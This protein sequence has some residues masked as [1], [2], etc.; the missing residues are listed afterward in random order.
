MTRR[1]SLGGGHPIG[2][3]IVGPDG[4]ALL[5]LGDRSVW[6]RQ[7]SF[8][9][10]SAYPRA[11]ALDHLKAINLTARAWAS[12]RAANSAASDGAGVIL[13]C[14]SAGTTA[15]DRS[16]DN[17]LTWATMTNTSASWHRVY[18]LGGKFWLIANDA[19]II[20][21]A[22]SVTGAAGTWTLRTVTGSGSGTF[23]L[24]S[25]ELDWTG[26]NLVVSVVTSTPS[27]AIHTS[28]TG[29]TWTARTFGGAILGASNRVAAALGSGVVIC[30]TNNSYR[31]STDHGVTWGSL[32]GSPTSSIESVW[33]VGN[34]FYLAGGGSALS[35]W[36]TA[37]PSS[38]ASWA[39][40]TLPIIM[41]QSLSTSGL[42]R[43]YRSS[44][45][46]FAYAQGTIN[47]RGYALR[48]DAS[49]GY[50][51]RR[52]N[53][54]DVH[55]TANEAVLVVEGEASLVFSTVASAASYGRAACGWDSFNAVS[56]GRSVEASAAIP[57][58]LYVRVA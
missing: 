34:R 58:N 12:A 1:S 15:L 51:V 9:Q 14:A 18:F 24:Q 19:D 11:A 6:L 17:G 46:D 43:P 27:L 7:G 45:R 33:S 31:V 49:G 8:A 57:R 44:A 56:L 53:Q 32:I 37:D 40:L 4:E 48:F 30:P 23:M 52:T 42:T 21:L 20:T 25:A 13:S 41:A 54:F 38:T 10:A 50:T 22:E 5:T 28:P 2:D 26:S 36:T 39:Q 47:A 16:T 35:V 29:V 3:M 55:N